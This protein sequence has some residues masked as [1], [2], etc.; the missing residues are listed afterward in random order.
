MGSGTRTVATAY[1][2]R[3]G[4]AGTERDFPEWA[5]RGASCERFDAAGDGAAV[6]GGRCGLDWRSSGGVVGSGRGVGVGRDEL[7][8]CGCDFEGPEAAWASGFE[9]VIELGL[10]DVDVLAR[11]GTLEE[12]GPEVIEAVAKGDGEHAFVLEATRR[13]EHLQIEGKEHLADGMQP[14]RDVGVLAVEGDGGVVASN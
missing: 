4:E 2:Y 11:E 10:A 9:L 6:S 1:G 7:G 8:V 3:G 12:G 5:E 14:A 13:G